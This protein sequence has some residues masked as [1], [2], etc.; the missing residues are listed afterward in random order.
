[1]QI[2]KQAEQTGKYLSGAVFGVYRVSD[3]GKITE[4]TTNADGE[5][6]Y[7]LENGDY[8]LRELKAPYGYIAEAARIYFTVSDGATVKVE[9]TN[10]RDPNITDAEIPGGNITVPKTG[11][12][13]PT[14]NYVFGFTLLALAALCGVCLFGASKFKF[15]KGAPS[16]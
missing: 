15:A 12:D 3:N 10:L 6:S 16:I 5:A 13:F 4:L 9:V 14:M 8:Y 1:L 11:E 2:I 7:S